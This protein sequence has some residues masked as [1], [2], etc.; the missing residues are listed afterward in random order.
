[1]LATNPK[2]SEPR[3]NGLSHNFQAE[4]V[5]R[6]QPTNIPVNNVHGVF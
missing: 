2:Y 1:M 3:H 6:V 4:R 5:K